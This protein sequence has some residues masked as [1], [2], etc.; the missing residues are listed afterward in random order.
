[1]IKIEK[2]PIKW[3]DRK[4]F[5]CDNCG[6]EMRFE[7]YC[8]Y[9]EREFHYECPKCGLR[10][11]SPVDLCKSQD[12]IQQLYYPKR[13]NELYTKYTKQ[14][15]QKKID[16][17]DPLTFIP[18][19]Q[20]MDYPYLEEEWENYLTKSESPDGRIISKYIA[21]MRLKGYQGFTWADSI[22]INMVRKKK[23]NEFKNLIKEKQEEEGQ[24]II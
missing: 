3:E 11:V 24:C 2:V 13:N 9:N 19:L 5:C 14:E 15:I 10:V 7:R 6:E 16:P 21:R 22:F 20:D 17:H 1:M 23:R 12:N 18:F 8:I 4:V